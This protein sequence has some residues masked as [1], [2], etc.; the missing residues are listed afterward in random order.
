MFE[1]GIPYIKTTKAELTKYDAEFG[2]V[3][4]GD[5]RFCSTQAEMNRY[6]AALARYN[7]LFNKKWIVKTSV[8]G[9]GWRI[10]VY[11]E[12]EWKKLTD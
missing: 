6:K 5:S 11:S 7:K 10:W 9:K 4:S 3:K 12:E 8:Y 1:S 2:D